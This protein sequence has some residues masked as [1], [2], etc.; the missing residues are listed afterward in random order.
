MSF[1]FLLSRVLFPD[2]TSGRDHLSSSGVAAGIM[3]WAVQR[4]KRA[5]FLHTSIP[6]C[7]GKGLPGFPPRGGAPA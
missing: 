4:L 1:T 2:V 5:F 3:R 6:P 7:Y